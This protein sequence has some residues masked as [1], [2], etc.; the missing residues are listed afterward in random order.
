MAAEVEILVMLSASKEEALRRLNDRYRLTRV[1]ITHDTYLTHPGIPLLAASETMSLVGALRI[2]ATPKAEK[3]TAK[4]DIFN[5]DGTWS[6]SDEVEF[7]VSDAKIAREFF[8]LLGFELLLDIR[9]EKTFF[10]GG[11]FEV[12]LEDVEGLGLFLEIEERGRSTLPPPERKALVQAELD[13]IGLQYTRNF[14][15]GKPELLLKKRAGLPLG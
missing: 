6:H 15:G 8:A 5:T 14:D 12:V 13:A 2:R 9:M 1:D 11:G 10:D 3:L 4:R 7:A